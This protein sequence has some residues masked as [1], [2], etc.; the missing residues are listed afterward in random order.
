[1]ATADEKADL[2]MAAGTAKNCIAV[3]ATVS[4][5]TSANNFFNDDPGFKRPSACNYRLSP[6]SRARNAGDNAAWAGLAESVDLDGNP[7]IKFGTVDCGCYECF[8]TPTLFFVR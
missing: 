6:G 3:K 4:G 8:D 5:G 2:Y 7:R 1:M